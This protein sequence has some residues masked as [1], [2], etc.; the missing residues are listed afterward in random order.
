M[1]SS[2]KS[3]LKPE[4]VICQMGPLRRCIERM[5]GDISSCLVEVELF[6]KT[7]KVPS[8]IHDRDGLDDPRTGTFG[9]KKPT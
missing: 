1:I 9:D 6:E 5:E 3:K 7:C 2:S 8:Y 4:R